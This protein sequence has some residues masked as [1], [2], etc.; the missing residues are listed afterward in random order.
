MA[1]STKISIGMAI[2]DLTKKKSQKARGKDGKDITITTSIHVSRISDSP[3]IL[4]QDEESLFKSLEKDLDTLKQFNELFSKGVLLSDLENA[5]LIYKKSYDG[6]EVV[7]R[8]E[9]VQRCRGEGAAG[10]EVQ[11]QRFRG[12]EV[13][14]SGCRGG[15]VVIVQKVLSA[16]V[17]QRY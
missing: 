16:G 4:N 2:N 15:A 11:V 17:Q 9:V 8:R 14:L 7:Q 6:A 12:A 13:L 3:F 10:E 1:A 5:R